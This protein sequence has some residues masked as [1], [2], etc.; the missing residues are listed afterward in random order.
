M[1]WL[2]LQPAGRAGLPAGGAGRSRQQL[3]L[4]HGSQARMTRLRHPGGRSA[5]LPLLSSSTWAPGRERSALTP[6]A[7]PCCG[8]AQRHGCS[9][10]EASACRRRPG[11][12][13]RQVSRASSTLM[14]ASL[15][16]SLAR[17]MVQV[18]ATALVRRGALATPGTRRCRGG[19]P[20]V[21]LRPARGPRTG[22]TPPWRLLSRAAQGTTSAPRPYML[23]DTE[24]WRRGSG[25]GR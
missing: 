17:T 11:A 8:Q 15:P 7:R 4:A 1:P 23:Q 10:G 13:G 21:A 6:H 19:L 22:C 16:H 24:A 25:C 14:R 3:H 12:S 9:R 2:L 20:G 5:A 18:Q